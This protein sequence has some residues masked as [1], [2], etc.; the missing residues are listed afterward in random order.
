MKSIQTLLLLLITNLLYSQ[1]GN[2]DTSF[3]NE[4]KSII[5]FDQ[6]SAEANA[7]VIQSDGKIVLSGIGLSD[8]DED[9]IAARYLTN[10][11]IDSSF[12]DNGKIRISMSNFRDRCYDVAVDSFNNIFLTGFTFNNNFE[13]KGFVIKLKSNGKIDSTFAQNGIWL[14]Q[15]PDTREDFR[16]ILIQENGNIF[17]A[18]ETEIFGQE[19]AATVVKLNTSGTL[20]SSFGENGIAKVVV[21]DSYNPRFAKLN[22]NEEIITGGF[23]LDNS[24]NIILT[25]FTQ[26]G[27]SDT[28]FG[29]NGIVIDNSPLDEFAR[30]IAIQ[31]DNKILVATGVT[32]ASGRDFGLV[33]FNIDGTLDNT[34]GINGKISTDFS[35][36]SN[37]AHS[38]VLQENGKILLSGFL[39][40][41]P[42]HDYAIARY[43]LL[44]NLDSSFGDEGKII[45]DFGLDDLAFTSAIQSDG[46]LICAGNSKTTDDN[47]SF[48]IAR[49]FTDTET[50]ASNLPESIN[51]ISLFP[52]PSNGQFKLVLDLNFSNITSIDLINLNGKVIH[53]IAENTFFVEGLNTVE[54]DLN[55]DLSSG[56]Y[57][58]R[59]QSEK[60]VTSQKILIKR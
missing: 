1:A 24:V 33:R 6:I 53:K 29:T 21:P 37:T 55:K 59:I 28:S 26:T 52:N 56:L 41:T 4:G 8:S 60:E 54:I 20:D 34:F 42:N 19:T 12:G 35:Q 18:G 16:Q 27:E 5:E 13:P 39:G 57:L 47:S 38:I 30:D 58:I 36:T 44:G 51:Y 7:V 31:N 23:L 40:I 46:K 14:S 49:Y 2:L 45:T 32:T 3:G 43:D 50:S 9:I 15:E 11:Q 10:G 22:S 17:I 48:S 25:K